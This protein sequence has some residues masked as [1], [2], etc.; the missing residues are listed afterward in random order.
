MSLVG[1]RMSPLKYQR[2]S[3]SFNE[4]LPIKVAKKM[5]Q[6]NNSFPSKDGRLN[7]RIIRKSV[8]LIGQVPIKI[9]VENPNLAIQHRENRINLFY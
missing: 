7:Y 1:N 5:F 2:I 6:R 4:G 8:F 9:W 3:D